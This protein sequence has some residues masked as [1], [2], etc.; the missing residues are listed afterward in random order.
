MV[1]AAVIGSSVLSA[2]AGIYASQSAASQQKKAAANAIATQRGMYDQTRADLLPFEQAGASALNP[3]MKLATGDPRQ[4]QSQL[5][6]LP[7]YQFTNT[8][9]LKAVQ[10]S[11]AARGLGSS[12]AALKGAANFATGL[13]NSTYGDQFNRLLGLSQLGSGAASSLGGFATAT[14]QGIAGSQIGAGNAG[15]AGTIGGANAVS[16]GLNSISNYY[17]TNSLLTKL[18]GAG[19]AGEGG[20]GGP[21][22]S[23]STIF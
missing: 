10:N 15:A 21:S 12:G 13:A 7:G 18:S 16:G 3:L 11:A 20:G 17:L 2:G 14:G 5:E 8:Q 4:V 9:G 22:G 6:Q 23:A 19:Q 1:A